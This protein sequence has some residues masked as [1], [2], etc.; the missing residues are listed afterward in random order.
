MGKHPCPSV[1]V[2]DSQ[3]SC[4]FRYPFTCIICDY[5]G[6]KQR[7]FFRKKGNI[8][9]RYRHILR[10][11][12]RFMQFV[13]MQRHS[14]VAR[15]RLSAH[16]ASIQICATVC[17]ASAECRTLRVVSTACRSHGR[18]WNPSPTVQIPNCVHITKNS[19]DCCLRSFVLASTYLPGPLPAK[20]C[21]H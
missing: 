11:S 17:G 5:N 2:F 9:Y 8:L 7:Q 16:I 12:H 13:S 10:R 21:Q 19:A 1:V 3:L 6:V 4:N 20:Y 15:G 14:A 18:G